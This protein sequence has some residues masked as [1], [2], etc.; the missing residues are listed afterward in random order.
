M[1]TRKLQRVGGGTFTV[2]I[3]KEWAS[4]HGLEAGREV[5]ITPHTDG[6]LV[7]QMTPEGKAKLASVTVDLDS[8][9]AEHADRALTS[10]YRAGYETVTIVVPDSR[11]RGVLE[12]IE[13]SVTGLIGVELTGITDTEITVRCLLDASDVSIRQSVVQLA[14]IASVTLE[15]AVGSL[16]DGVDDCNQIPS[17][18]TEADRIFALIDRHFTRAFIDLGEVDELGISRLQLLHYHATARWLHEIIGYGASLS[19]LARDRPNESYDGV[20]VDLK[21]VGERSRTVVRRATNALIETESKGK[22]IDALELRDELVA[23]IE[24]I[25]VQQSAA[26]FEGSNWLLRVL[27]RFTQILAACEEIGGVS[28]REGNYTARE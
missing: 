20:D 25:R 18:I 10:L 9:T 2:S 24:S 16:P 22:T 6:T 4:D 1:E 23:E 21:S 14:Y 5:Y 13:A 28:L 7:L 27:D 11:Y 15:S 12:Q 26:E 17:R 19:A 3:P 8:R